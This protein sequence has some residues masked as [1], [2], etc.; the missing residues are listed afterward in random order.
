[1]SQLLAGSALGGSSMSFADLEEHLKHCF[2][3]QLE[4]RRPF[5]NTTQKESPA[6]RSKTLRF[7]QKHAQIEARDELSPER[8]KERS[9]RHRQDSNLRG[10]NPIDF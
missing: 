5:F 2:E 7:G 4:S 10:I 3:Q 8:A 6:S 9:Y 1:M